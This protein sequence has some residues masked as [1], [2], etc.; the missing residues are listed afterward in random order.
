VF[1]FLDNLIKTT[2]GVIAQ[3]QQL[4]T[5]KAMAQAQAQPYSTVLPTM[6]TP[7][8]GDGIGLVGWTAIIGVVGAGAYY[9]MKR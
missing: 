9:F 6:Y 3:Q 1:G 2:G 7:G 8:G 4:Q 5:A